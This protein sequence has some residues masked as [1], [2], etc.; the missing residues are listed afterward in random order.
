M[1]LDFG[2]PRRHP[3]LLFPAPVLKHVDKVVFSEY[4]EL[5]TDARATLVEVII[6]LGLVLSDDKIPEP[7][8][9]QEVLGVRVV[10]IPPRGRAL[11]GF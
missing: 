2:C 1:G 4:A 6:L 11:D 3:L 9:C 10:L 5:L 8:F 7:A